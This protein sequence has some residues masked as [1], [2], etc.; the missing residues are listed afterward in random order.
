MLLCKEH[1]TVRIDRTHSRCVISLGWPLCWCADLI[2]HTW[3]R[4]NRFR[5]GFADEP[6]LSVVVLIAF[7]KW[8]Y[9]WQ[10]YT[11][12]WSTFFSSRLTDLNV[13][14][15]PG[16]PLPVPWSNTPSCLRVSCV[17]FASIYLA[18]VAAEDNFRSGHWLV[19]VKY[20]Q[21][22]SLSCCWH[23]VLDYSYSGYVTYPALG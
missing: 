20:V 19:I 23:D 22:L 16:Q 4:H 6:W 8:G 21:G 17:T 14:V 11:E 15:Y 5:N 1:V 12:F 2:A 7:G 10:S 3:W 13:T 9:G 18:A